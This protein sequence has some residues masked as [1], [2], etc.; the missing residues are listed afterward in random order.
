MSNSVRR[1]GVPLGARLEMITSHPDGT[2]RIWTGIRSKQVPPDRYIGHYL[3][4]R[5]DGS[6][7]TGGD[8]EEVEVMSPRHD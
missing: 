3:E 5:T 2:W 4:I 1:L 8:D 6:V 7:W